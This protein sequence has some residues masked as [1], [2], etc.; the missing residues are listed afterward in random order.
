MPETLWLNVPSPEYEALMLWLPIGKDEEVSFA[1]L[2]TKFTVPRTLNPSVKVTAPVGV[3]PL[4]V[5][6]T[7]TVNVTEFPE[8]DGLAE[9]VRVTALPPVFSSIVTLSVKGLATARSAAPSRLKS[10]I[11]IEAGRD[12]K[13]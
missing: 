8:C 2:A 5:G 13:L 9:L 3:P 1:L 11:T 10:A 7:V 4:K 12:P 6:R